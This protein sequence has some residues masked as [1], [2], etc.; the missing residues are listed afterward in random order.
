[1]RVVML[2]ARFL[3]HAGAE[4]PLSIGEVY[5]LPDVVA[6]AL[7]EAG[8]AELVPVGPSETKPDPVVLETK[9]KR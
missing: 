6:R 4:R 5:E 2:A 1:M 8:D 7:L 3:Q 9:R